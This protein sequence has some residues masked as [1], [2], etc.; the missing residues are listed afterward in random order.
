[1]DVS[2][3]LALCVAVASATAFIVTTSV[4][5]RANTRSMDKLE[6]RIDG[7]DNRITT[8]D[9]KFTSKINA[10]ETRFAVMEKDV[11]EIKSLCRERNASPLPV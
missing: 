7:L 11:E 9:N 4:S 1:M 8:L 3:V 2:F 5:T 6:K 10:L